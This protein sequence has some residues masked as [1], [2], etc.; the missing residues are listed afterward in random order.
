MPGIRSRL[1]GNRASRDQTLTKSHSRIADREDLSLPQ[2]RHTSDGGIWVAPARLLLNE[3]RD[4][5]LELRRTSLP[6]LLGELL[7]AC[8]N[9]IAAGTCCQVADDARLNVDTLLHAV[10]PIPMNPDRAMSLGEPCHRARHGCRSGTGPWRGD[11]KGP[12]LAC[13]VHREGLLRERVQASG[14]SIVLLDM[15]SDQ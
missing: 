5:Q 3:F 9:D 10:L 1:T 11:S 2:C 4:D 8:N 14:R 12:C 6:P 13:A 15:V 7:M